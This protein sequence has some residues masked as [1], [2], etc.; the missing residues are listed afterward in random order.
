MCA[1]GHRTLRTLER[2]ITRVYGRVR[3]VLDRDHPWF[4]A[5]VRARLLAARKAARL[6][7]QYSARESWS[8]SPAALFSSQLWIAAE[9]ALEV[10]GTAVALANRLVMGSYSCWP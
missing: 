3:G 1:W 10:A 9:E 6:A 7:V 5:V 8:R 4:G 2:G